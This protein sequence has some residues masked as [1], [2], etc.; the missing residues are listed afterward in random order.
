MRRIAVG[1]ISSARATGLRRRS[2]Y[3]RMSRS[4][5]LA[6]IIDS[7]SGRDVTLRLAVY[8]RHVLSIEADYLCGRQM[9]R[10]RALWQLARFLETHPPAPPA[11]VEI[12]D[13]QG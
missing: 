4:Q 8:P 12:W 3:R 6:R 9:E 10:W 2:K 13:F 5:G 7:V 11:S 1:T